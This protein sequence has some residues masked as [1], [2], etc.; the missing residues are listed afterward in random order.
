[1]LDPS[2]FTLTKSGDD[3]TLSVAT[4]NTAKAGDY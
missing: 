1:M 3:Y 4:S 2:I